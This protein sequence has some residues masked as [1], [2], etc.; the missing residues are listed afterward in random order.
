MADIDYDAQNVNKLINKPISEPSLNM[1]SVA[2]TKQRY[3]AWT[4]E[5]IKV[6]MLDS[7][8]NER[9]GCT[10]RIPRHKLCAEFLQDIINRSPAGSDPDGSMLEYLRDSSGVDLIWPHEMQSVSYSYLEAVR[11]QTHSFTN[12]NIYS[13]T[14]SAHSK[15]N[16][17]PNLLNTTL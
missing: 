1:K 5:E 10:W 6:S 2:R 17:G 3:N 8:G 11:S 13:I 14:P 16:A 7:D 4:H 12:P 9:P 15:R